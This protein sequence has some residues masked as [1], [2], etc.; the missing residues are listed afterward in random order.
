MLAEN[1]IKNW[2][3]VVKHVL[4]C[5]P[6]EAC[7]IVTTDNV[8]IPYD[9]VSANPKET[10]E[11]DSSAL[12]DHDV[13]CILHSHVYDPNVELDHDPRIPSKLDMQGQVDTDVEWAIV[14]TEGE[15]VT[16]PYF[17]GDYS[18]RPPLMDR[19]FI[20]CIQ[21]CLCFMADWQYKER[22]I[23]LPSC[24]RDW[25]WFQ[26]GDDFIEKL[27]GEWGFVDVTHLPEERGDVNLYSIRAECT[28]HIG[29]VL[30][31]NLHVHHFP[32]R[33]PEV[34]HSSV[35]ERHFVKRIRYTK[36]SSR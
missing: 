29:V 12:V 9:N 32:N 25:D 15:N 34:V 5:Y 7:G 20:H 14:V 35:W 10:F 26:K 3:D 24:P 23:E 16:P 22:G 6:E 30:E 36:K 28:N 1:Y 17:F 11:L 31:P 27:F 18:H 13:K 21:D 4:N 8:F 2:D 19:E 33:M